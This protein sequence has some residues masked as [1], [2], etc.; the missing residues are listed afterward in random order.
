MAAVLT[1]DCREARTEV[2]GE[3]RRDQLG[4]YCIILAIDDGGLAG[5]VTVE[6]V[7]IGWA[8]EKFWR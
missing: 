3:K 8:L 2:E 1:V 6:V 4:S 7:R 5:S